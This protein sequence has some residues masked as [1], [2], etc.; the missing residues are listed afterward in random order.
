MVLVAIIKIKYENTKVKSL[1][2]I[3]ILHAAICTWTRKTKIKSK[4]NI[5]PIN[6]EGLPPEPASMTGTRSF[7]RFF[8]L[9]PYP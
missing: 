5:M 6:N 8:F 7:F 1:A 9:A 2:W 4:K 3:G